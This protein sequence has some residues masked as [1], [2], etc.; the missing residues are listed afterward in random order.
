MALIDESVILP[1]FMNKIT[2]TITITQHDFILKKITDEDTEIHSHPNSFT[3]FDRDGRVI[4]ECRYMRDGSFEEMIEYDF[5]DHNRVNCERYYLSEDEI[6]EVV[7]YRY[8]DSGKAVSA[9]KKYADGSVDT[10]D[11]EYD[12]EGRLF[13]KVYRN[14]E[15]EVEQTEHYTYNQGTLVKVE[16][17]DGDGNLMSIPFQDESLSSHSRVTRNEAG[18]VIL[19]EEFDINGE[20]IMS[21]QRDYQDDGKPSRVEVFMNGQGKTISRHYILTYDYTYFE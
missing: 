5:D 1:L 8:N 21:V 9:E 13:R 4:R 15:Q 11:F 3:E 10:I 6:S 16:S 14:D 12:G 17:F 2:K 20:V 7:E 18:Q 19:E